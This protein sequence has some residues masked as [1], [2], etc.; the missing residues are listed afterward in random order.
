VVDY[1]FEPMP[2]STG[3][4]HLN[5]SATILRLDIFVFLSRH[6]PMLLQGPQNYFR[7]GT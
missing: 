3:T 6:I 1:G 7:S 5:H 4:N 2:E